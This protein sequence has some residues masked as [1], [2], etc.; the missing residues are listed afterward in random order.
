[1]TIM[2]SGVIGYGFQKTTTKR[3]ERQ[4]GHVSYQPHVICFSALYSEKNIRLESMLVPSFGNLV[5][6]FCRLMRTIME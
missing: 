2:G 1:M 3:K 6:Q 4:Y 5:T